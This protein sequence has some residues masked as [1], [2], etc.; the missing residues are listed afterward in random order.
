MPPVLDAGQPDA[1]TPREPVRIHHCVPGAAAALPA[2][3][4]SQ[5]QA[6]GALAGLRLVYPYT[7]TVL[8]RGL[9]APLWMWDGLDTDVDPL[10]DSDPVTAVYIHVT[11]TYFEYSG[12]LVPTG[13]GQLAFPEDVWDMA[14]ANTLGSSDPFEVELTVLSTSGV[15]GPVTQEIVIAQASL[16]GSIYYNSYT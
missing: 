3:T 14:E 1:G 10:L 7:Q 12:C 13:P 4:I 6:G 11:A 16:K 5:L 8:P 2:D 9:S 15:H